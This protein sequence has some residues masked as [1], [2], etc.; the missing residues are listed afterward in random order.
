[1]LEV[2]TKAPDFTLLNQNGEEISLSQYRGQKVILYFYPKD[3]TPGC[4]KQACGFAQLYPDFVK[5]GAVILAVPFLHII[6]L[7][8]YT[9]VLLNPQ[10]FSQYSQRRR[11]QARYNHRS[12]IQRLCSQ[13]LLP[14]RLLRRASCRLS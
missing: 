10:R 6:R 5:K 4:T 13:F 3:N 9:K 8:I 14:W 11:I 7:I 2:G 1:M 12:R